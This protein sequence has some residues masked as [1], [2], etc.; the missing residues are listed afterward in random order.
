VHS[1]AKLS[2]GDTGAA[3]G[4]IWSIS[5]PEKS[6]AFCEKILHYDF[7]YKKN[8]PIFAVPNLFGKLSLA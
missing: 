8:K 1:P 4:W 7:D 3:A 5:V 2:E 6:G